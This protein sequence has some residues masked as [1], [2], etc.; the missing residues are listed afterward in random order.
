MGAASRATAKRASPASATRRF[1][2]P[3]QTA[4]DRC[5]QHLR[6]GDGSNIAV[7]SF[8]PRSTRNMEFCPQGSGPRPHPDDE[9]HDSRGTSICGRAVASST[10]TNHG[11]IATWPSP[12]RVFD[13]RTVR[14]AAELT[15]LDG[16]PHASYGSDPTKRTADSA[17]DVTAESGSFY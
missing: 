2:T 11:D 3:A 8:D 7:M 10:R 16:E 5:S 14:S 17:A 13:A 1:P 6:A 9:R 12:T 15:L 4:T